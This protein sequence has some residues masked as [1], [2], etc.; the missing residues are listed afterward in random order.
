LVITAR[1]KKAVSIE[2]V[3]GFGKTGCPR[4]KRYGGGKGEDVGDSYA[5]VPATE[6]TRKGLIKKKVKA[7]KIILAGGHE[8]W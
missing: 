5:S 3:T 2:G 7:A 1:Q 4:E 6:I 8:T